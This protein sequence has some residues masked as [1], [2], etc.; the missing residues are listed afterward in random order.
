MAPVITHIDTK[1]PV[2]FLGI[3]DGA[4]KDPSVVK[5]MKDNHIKASLFLAQEFIADNPDFFR[6]LVAAGSL[7]EDH[8]LSHDV[9]MADQSYE[10]QRA[11]ICG[12]AD[13]EQ[14]EYGRRPIFFR[15]PGGAYSPTMLRAANDC[16]MKAVIDWTAKANGG[17]MQYQ[18]GEGLQAGDVVLMH[19]RPMFKQDLQAFIDAEK[20]AGLHTELI[21]SAAN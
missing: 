14:Q 3:D 6:Q 9:T 4:Y 10:H 7:V 2:V 12:M 15:P 16:G 19:F 11:E 20:A 13:Y 1:Q 8:T 5:L 21:E 18:V 17:A